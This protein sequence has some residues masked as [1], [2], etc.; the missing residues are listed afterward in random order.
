MRMKKAGYSEDYRKHVLLNAFAVWDSKIEKDLNGECP[1]NRPT[2]YRK[3][4]RRK[5]KIYKKKNWST[6]G[7]YIAPIIVPATPNGILA[8]MLKSAAESNNNEGIKFKII[9]KGGKTLEKILKSNVKTSDSCGKDD[10]Y[11]DNQVENGRM[12]HKSNVLYEWQC[13][14]CN[15]KYIGETSRNFYTRALEHLDKADKKALD[16]FITS[17]QKEV[18]ND[19]EPSFAVKVLKSFK[20]PLSR[21]VYEGVYIRN[22]EQSLNTKLDYYQTSTYRMRRE[23]LH[24]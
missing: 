16:S 15:G 8:K 24:G 5:E 19:S 3:N 1:L 12:C 14:I 18:H 17:H 9:E 2:G 23:I 7:G 20:E 22:S 11:M 6:K 13:R 4:E 21:M 10:C